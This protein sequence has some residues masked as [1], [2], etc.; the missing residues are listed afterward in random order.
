MITPPDEG[1]YNR[2]VT[3]N[4]IDTYIQSHSLHALCNI[5]LGFVFQDPVLLLVTV[6]AVLTAIVPG[7][8]QHVSAVQTVY[9]VP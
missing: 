2:I 5:M 9:W 1:L 6:L 7:T 8:L 4:S 3:V